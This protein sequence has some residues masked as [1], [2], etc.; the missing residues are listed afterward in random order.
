MA[1]I[2]QSYNNTSKPQ[3]PPVKMKILKERIYVK[4]LEILVYPFPTPAHMHTHLKLFP[5]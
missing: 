5:L 1:D 3:L 4:Y 2:Y